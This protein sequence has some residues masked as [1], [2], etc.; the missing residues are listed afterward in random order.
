MHSDSPAFDP[1]PLPPAPIVSRDT[2]HRGP[3]PIPPGVPYHRV[4]AGEKRRVGRGILALVLLLVGL[5]GIGGVVSVL[6]SAVDQAL[7]RVNPIAGGT[8][9]TPIYHAAN[10]VSIALLIPWSMVVQRWLYGVKGASLHS[11][12]SAFRPDVLGRAVLTVVP[13]WAV[14]MTVFFLLSPYT[15]GSWRFSDLVAVFVIT[16]LLT[17]LQSAGE[18]YGYR[19]LAFR[20]AASW[21]RGPRTALVLGLAVSSILFAAIHMSTDPWLNVYYLTLG[22]T[23]GLITWRTGGLETSTVIHAAN[24]TL[25]YLLMLVTHADPLADA[26]RSAGAGSIVMLLP[27]VLLAAITAVFWARTRRTGPPR[28]PG[29]ERMTG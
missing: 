9:F 5:F 12:S 23:F 29:H 13:I 18:E 4:L 11:V 21:G 27:C 16:L 17:P 20:V 19:G 24:N 6:G 28:T 10:L 14:Y 2:P 26:D 25:V 3:R 15:E 7:G 1:G 22:V 8:E